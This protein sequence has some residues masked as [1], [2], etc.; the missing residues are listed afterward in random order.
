MV[1]VASPLLVLAARCKRCGAPPPQRITPEE[2]A[3]FEA[4]DPAR[5]VGT[6]RCPACHRVYPVHVEAYQR[7]A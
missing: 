6:F 3:R 4:D 5:L 7:A 2:R 1:A